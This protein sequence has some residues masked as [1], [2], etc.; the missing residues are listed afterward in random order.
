MKFL[1]LPLFVLL[2]F[3]SCEKDT[4]GLAPVGQNQLVT[5]RSADKVH[6]CHNGH[7]IYISINAL[8]AHLNHLGGSDAV[9]LDNDGYYDKASPCGGIDC[10][11]NDPGVGESCCPTEGLLVVTLP[12]NS[13]LYVYPTDNSVGIQWGGFGI[14]ITGCPNI[15]NEPDA[16]ADFNGESNT[17]AIVSQLGAGTYAAKLCADLNV[18]GCDDWYLPSAGELDAIYTQLGPSGSN[19]FGTGA[20]WSSTEYFSEYAWYKVFGDGSL[21]FDDKTNTFNCRCVRK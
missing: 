6:V 5:S 11:D 2:I 8:P 19:G 15:D 10:N 4:S 13:T 17:Q 20:Y 1:F 14:D 7:V 18:G 9:D 3:T 21:T 16:L 12:D